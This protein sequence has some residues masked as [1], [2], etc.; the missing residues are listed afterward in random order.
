MTGSSE[1]AVQNQQ[2]LSGGRPASG[3]NR[4]ARRGG[5]RIYFRIR[6]QI[7]KTE[8][9]S[10]DVFKDPREERIWDPAS[11]IHSSVAERN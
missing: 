5:Q 8:G 10:R 6:G 7:D 11:D 9:Y 4:S 3:G 1:L 2:L